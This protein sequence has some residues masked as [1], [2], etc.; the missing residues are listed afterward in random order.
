MNR[1]ISKTSICIML[2]VFMTMTFLTSWGWCAEFKADVIVDKDG[3]I[4]DGVVYVKD[5]NVRYELKTETGE[6]IIIYPGD[7]GAQWTIYPNS[8]LYSELWNYMSDDYIVVELNRNLNEIATKEFI[9]T[10]TI[11][12]MLCDIYLYRF[13][14][15]SLGKL[16]IYHAQELDYPIKMELEKSGYRLT[17]EYKNI[18]ICA[19][20]DSLFELPPGYTMLK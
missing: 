20:K 16:T 12:G 10:Q 14:D 6:E 5:T 9:G 4:Y 2:S 15:T 7:F 18:K 11:A 1:R 13:H 19:L 8:E 3:K 17:K